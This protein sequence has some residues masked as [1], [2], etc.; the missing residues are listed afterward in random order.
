[1]GLLPILFMLSS[2]T[3]NLHQATKN[4]KAGL[5]LYQ[6]SGSGGRTAGFRLASTASQVADYKAIFGVGAMPF[7]K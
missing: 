7:V 3:R 1:M 6:T 2:T 4:P 5:F